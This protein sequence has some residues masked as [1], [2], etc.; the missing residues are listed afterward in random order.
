MRK[1]TGRSKKGSGL[2]AVVD[3]QMSLLA[4]TDDVSAK[5]QKA[6]S[7]AK[8]SYDELPPY[9]R[10]SDTSREAA[11]EIVGC[12]PTMRQQVLVFLMARGAYGATDDEGEKVLNMRH[13]TYS[14]RRRWLVKHGLVKDSGETRETRSGRSAT[15]WVYQA[16]LPF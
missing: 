13:Q 15:V 16:P 14:A 8:A 5:A 6:L 7:K 1:S 2:G 4:G 3:D 12:A 11:E 9:V 10:G